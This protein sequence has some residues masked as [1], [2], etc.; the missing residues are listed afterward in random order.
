MSV[1]K[2]EKH[3]VRLPT[4]V[5][6][7]ATAFAYIAH[8]LT[9]HR[10]LVLRSSLRS[11]PRICK[12]KRYCKHKIRSH[13]LSPLVRHALS[14]QGGLCP[15]G[16]EVAWGVSDP[17]TYFTKLFGSVIE[18]RTSVREV[19][20]SNSGRTNTQGLKIIKEKVLPSL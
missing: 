16:A 2:R 20:G 11:S 9:T 3:F 6:L 12:K 17:Q 13:A 7:A 4:P 8:T 5:L 19:D 14:P 18:H 1:S 15:P 10:L